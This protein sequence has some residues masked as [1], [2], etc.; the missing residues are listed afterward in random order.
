[1]STPMFWMQRNPFAVILRAAILFGFTV[2]AGGSLPVITKDVAILGGGASGTYAAV[3]LREDYG[4]SVVLIE[5]EAVL[6]MPCIPYGG[7]PS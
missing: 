7:R 5:K 2:G 1:M 4:K 3:R 6:V